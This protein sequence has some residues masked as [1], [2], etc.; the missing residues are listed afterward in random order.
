MQ[1]PLTS[2][3]KKTLRKKLGT[4]F[5][6]A[7][8]AILIFTFIYNFI[9][10]DFF[11]TD[12]SFKYIPIAIF[13][14][15]GLFFLGVII[16]MGKSILYDIK[17][18]V[19]NCFEGIV[20]DKRLAISKSTS[21]GSGVG[22]RGGSRTKTNIKRDYYITV[23][24]TEHKVEYDMYNHVSVGDKIYFE[25][26]PKSSIIIHYEVLEKVSSVKNHTATT[27]SRTEYPVSKV[28]QAPLSRPD[29]TIL[30]SFF[31]QKLGSRLK[32][33][34]FVGLPIVG[35]LWND[36]GG[37]LVFLFPLP[38]I[39]IY[40]L[41]KLVRL[42]INYNKSSNSGRKQLITTHVTDKVF[43]TISNNGSRSQKRTLKTTYGNLNVPE[44]MYQ[45]IDS[46]DEILIH[47]A[48]HINCIFGITLDEMYYPI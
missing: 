38:I 22:S 15:F 48:L 5:F 14:I 24:D 9:L 16:Y 42:Y 10:K 11:K 12:D 25:E 45:K 36:L 47:K 17:T 27:Q 39:L 40:Q 6:I 21:H 4:V 41:Y 23:N 3:D 29:R 37:L 20:E 46:G 26:A 43:T 31:K 33:I 19:K 1:K 18:G 44:K 13:G 30:Q 7:I 8:I 32:T 35:L 2:K 28:K 34:L